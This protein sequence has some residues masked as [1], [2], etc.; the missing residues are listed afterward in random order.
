MFSGSIVA[1]ATPM[2]EDCSLDFNSLEKLIENQ[3]TAGTDAIVVSGTTGESA[4]LTT[5][6]KLEL[7]KRSL[8][9]ANNRVPIIAGTGTNSTAVSIELTQQAK[10]L[11]VD[12]CLLVTPYYNRPMQHGLIAHYKSIANAVAIPQILYN[13]PTRTAVDL[14][15]DSIA[16]LSQEDNIIG[17]KEAVVDKNKWQQI[18]ENSTKDFVL[19]SG[20]DASCVECIECGA[21]GV[22]SVAA[23]I[24]PNMM[25]TMCEAVLEGKIE[26]A[27]ELNTKLQPLFDA[28]FIETNPIPVKYALK[29]KQSINSGIRLPL[30]QLS[31][32]HKKLITK[33][34]ANYK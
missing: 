10:D 9:I 21:K 27:N 19:Y 14:Q 22:I 13:V 15:V 31:D 34:V 4:T 20:D 30:T 25:H 8:A 29:L 2:N 24:A 32:S 3:I 26:Q 28:L 6:E 33:L 16:S 12:A 1:L 7:I 23:N 17:I 11:G 18:L 5:A